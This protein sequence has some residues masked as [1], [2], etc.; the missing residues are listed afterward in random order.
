MSSCIRFHE[1]SEDEILLS[2]ISKINIGIITGKLNILISIELFLTWWPIA[3]IR[4][5]QLDIL[6]D[7]INRRDIKKGYEVIKF[8][9][10]K[11]NNI[12]V[13]KVT[14][15]IKRKLYISLD[16]INSSG[17]NT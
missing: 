6:R 5:K 13:R 12:N 15:T 3:D 9:S 1:N 14:K 17:L 10:R 16:I 11:V 4:V 7:P 8:P 2:F